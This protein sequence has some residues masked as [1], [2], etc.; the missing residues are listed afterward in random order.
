MGKVKVE[1]DEFSA[2]KEKIDY[3]E[4]EIQRMKTRNDRLESAL[5]F[6]SELIP[7]GKLPVGVGANVSGWLINQGQNRTWRI[8]ER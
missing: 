1:Y 3:Q 7:K 4:R 8:K 5:A 6:A 2:M